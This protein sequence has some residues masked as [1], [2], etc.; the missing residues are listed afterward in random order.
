MS[1]IIKDKRYLSIFISIYLFSAI[2]L[3]NKFKIVNKLSIADALFAII[4]IAYIIVVIRSKDTLIS[5]FN[6]TIDFFKRPFVFFMSFLMLIMLISTSYASNKSI[7][8]NESFRFFIYL[9]LG[10]LI[11]YELSDS[12]SIG[13]IINVFLASTFVL[14]IL[15]IVQYFTKIGASVSLELLGT[16]QRIEATLGN[17]NAFGAYLVIALFP[18]IMLLIYEKNKAKKLFISIVCLLSLI[19]LQFTLS[20]N[21]WLSFAF[22][23]T[24]LTILYSWKFI[25]FILAGAG[26]A[27]FVPQIAA[28]VRQFGD[29]AHNQGRIKIWKIALKMIEDHPLRGVGNGNFSVLYDSY[30]AKYPEYWE[31]YYVEYPTHNVYLKFFSELGIFGLT[32]FL[33]ALVFALR[34]LFTLLRGP[35][36]ILK[37]FF[38][39]FFISTL[40]MLLLNFFDNILYVPQVAV[41]FWVFLFAAEGIKKYSSKANK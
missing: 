32:A 23:I 24:L 10:Y 12:K 5:F 39:G 38:T 13:L 11:I 2:V 31:M 9:S 26:A 17:P 41:L 35:E 19:N 29:P 8:L 21:A 16:T 1:S 6:N 3:P 14:D 20:R 34:N 25:I 30:V 33:L 7:A 27:L 22:G 36:S 18:C 37:Y 4:L 15:G 40:C 28:R